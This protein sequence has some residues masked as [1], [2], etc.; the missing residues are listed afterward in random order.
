MFC[1]NAECIFVL[2]LRSAGWCWYHVPAAWQKQREDS[3]GLEEAML[4]TKMQKT[5][6]CSNGAILVHC[7]LE[8]SKGCSRRTVTWLVGGLFFSFNFIFLGCMV[9]VII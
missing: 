6:Q 3:E 9:L 8:S 4:Q 1:R 7:L 2:D 5:T